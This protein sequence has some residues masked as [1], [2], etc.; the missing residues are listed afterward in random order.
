LDLDDQLRILQLL[1]QAGND[2]LLFA[3]LLDQRTDHHLGAALL[4]REDIDPA[5][6]PLPPLG[7]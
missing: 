5:L 7:G 4:G 6:L 3:V 2:G 1:G